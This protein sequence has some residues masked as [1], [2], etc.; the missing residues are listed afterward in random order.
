ML[1]VI[2]IMMEKIILFIK[3]KKNDNEKFYLEDKY[4]NKG[5]LYRNR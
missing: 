1:V 2:G 5:K 3:N 4:Y